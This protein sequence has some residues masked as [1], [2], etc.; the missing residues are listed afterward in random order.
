MTWERRL[1]FGAPS[2]LDPQRLLPFALVGSEEEIEVDGEPVRVR[3]YPWG[4][5]EVDN[6]KHSDTTALRSA[7]LSSHLTDLKE[8]SLT[9]SPSERGY[10]LC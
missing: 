4:L 1:I 7:L 9:F 6:P 10:L 2:L 3:R 8:V 5:V